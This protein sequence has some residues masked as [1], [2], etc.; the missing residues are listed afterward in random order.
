MS[1]PKNWL[2]YGATGYTGELIR[3]GPSPKESG[4]FWP[5]AMRK[6]SPSWRP[7]SIARAEPF[8]SM[9]RRR[10]SRR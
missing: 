8:R 3:A 5:V 6:R 10:L 7:S 2:L 1:E 9:S 4:R